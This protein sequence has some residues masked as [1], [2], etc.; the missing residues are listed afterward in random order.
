MAAIQKD[1]VS[2][3]IT[4]RLSKIVWQYN[5]E[6]IADFLDQEAAEMRKTAEIIRSLCEVLSSADPMQRKD[7]TQILFAQAQEVADIHSRI[8][9]AMRAVLK[10][11]I[12]ALSAFLQSP[13]EP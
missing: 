9:I 10:T 13:S 3:G 7:I 6:R 11:R 1:D 8:R 12:S 4:H 5:L 2:C